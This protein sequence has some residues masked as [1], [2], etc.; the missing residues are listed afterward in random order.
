MRNVNSCRKGA[1]FI[2]AGATT[3]RISAAADPFVQP[4]SANRIAI[5]SCV[6]IPSSW[7]KPVY[8]IPQTP[9]RET[10]L[11]VL[12]S[13]VCPFREPLLNVNFLSD[14]TTTYSWVKQRESASRLRSRLS[15]ALVQLQAHYHHCGEAA[16][17]KCLSAA[18][19]VR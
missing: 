19:F 10:S 14:A 7:E 9:Q 13:A 16:S 2:A 8:A 4:F 12:S 3:D 1:A 18:T 15:N 6:G 17:E 11:Q 5:H